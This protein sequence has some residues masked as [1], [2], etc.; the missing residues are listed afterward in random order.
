[1]LYS[2]FIVALPTALV[3]FTSLASFKNLLQSTIPCL[4]GFYAKLLVLNSYLN[5]GYYFIA[6]LAI[7]T[8]AISTANYLSLIVKANF[9]LPNYDHSFAVSTP[10]SYLISFI[11]SFIIFF[12]FNATYLDLVSDYIISFNI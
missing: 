5:V 7:L 10:L 3:F 1:M 12:I 8:S 9:S 4:P 6:L 2:F 11:S